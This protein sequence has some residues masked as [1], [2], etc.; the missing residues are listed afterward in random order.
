LRELSDCTSVPLENCDET[1][2]SPWHCH[3]KS[4]RRENIGGDLGRAE[5]EEWRIESVTWQSGENCSGWS[6]RSCWRG[7]Y[8]PVYL[9]LMLHLS[10]LSIKSW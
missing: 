6:S 1:V 5:T 4:T 7:I 3:R 2:S 9:R 10:R 8:S